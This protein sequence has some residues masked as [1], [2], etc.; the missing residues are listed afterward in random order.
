MEPLLGES[1]TANVTLRAVEL[2]R[3]RHVRFVGVELGGESARRPAT[4][5]RHAL[6]DRLRAVEPLTGAGADARPSQQ[7]ILERH[8]EL[9]L[10]GVMELRDDLGVAGTQTL[11]PAGHLAG[12]LDDAAVAAPVRRD[13]PLERVERKT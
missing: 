2:V 1:S 10:H 13:E 3:S 4:E 5:L 11:G 7:D 8:R 12:E 9:L 6:A